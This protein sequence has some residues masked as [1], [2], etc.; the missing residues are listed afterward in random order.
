VFVRIDLP[1][2]QQAVQACHAAIE[3]ARH[4]LFPP[5]DE[6]PHLVLCGARSEFSLEDIAA[7]LARLAIAHQPVFEP[8]LGG[9]L[10]ALCTEPL[11]GSRRVPLRRFSL[12]RTSFTS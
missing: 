3:A 5:G 6:H 2:P 4:G 8:D 1:P 11:R 7:R 12:L 10:T 9:Q